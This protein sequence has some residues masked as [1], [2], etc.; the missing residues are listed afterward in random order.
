MPAA[1]SSQTTTVTRFLTLLWVCLVVVGVVAPSYRVARLRQAAVVAE[2]LAAET[3]QPVLA[4]PV[5][6]VVAVE[7]PILRVERAPEALIRP[8]VDARLAAE[9]RPVVASW[10]GS[11][12]LEVRIDGRVAFLGGAGRRVPASVQ[13]LLTAAVALE[14][15]S[16][17]ERFVT[18]VRSV[19]G[20]DEGVI[21]GDLW[22]IGGGDPLITTVEYS[23]AYPRQPQLRTSIEDLAERIAATGVTRVNGRLLADETRYDQ[24]RYVASWPER[25]RDQHN[26]G[27]LSALT[28][29]DG[30]VRW[31]PRRVDA[32]DPALHF[33]DVLRRELAERGVFVRG[34]VGNGVVPPGLALLAAIESA[35]LSEIVKQMLRE[36]DNNTAESLLKELGWRRTGTGST[37]SGL[38]VVAEVLADVLPDEEPAVVM[39]GSGLDPA[40]L[41]SCGLLGSLLDFH[42]PNSVIGQGLPVAGVSGTL[43]HRF[44]DEPA[45]GRVA[46]KTGLLNGVNGL[47]GFVWND[48]GFVTFVQLLN[49]VPITGG[50]GFDLQDELVEVLLRHPGNLRADDL[51]RGAP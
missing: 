35:P 51:L 9:L 19:Q 8:V 12:C 41:V 4:R 14:V 40:N 15:M 10:Q 45:E 24:S 18:E 5:S 28:V 1:S 33:L 47:A 43:A 39:D 17:D 49:D 38:A 31:D 37:H 11:F 44:V 27:P 42:G 50:L 30:F 6:A 21:D 25:Y 29:N 23:D 22:V 46:A 13:K 48:D 26:S 2:Q 34:G 32:T 20:P 16:P 36:S 3:R 7:R